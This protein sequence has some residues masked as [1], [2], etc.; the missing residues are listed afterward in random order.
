VYLQTTVGLYCNTCPQF[1]HR[2][3]NRPFGGRDLIINLYD[4][5]DN[6][7]TFDDNIVEGD[8]YVVPGLNA[9]FDVQEVFSVFTNNDPNNL[10]K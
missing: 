3:W 6:K 1:Q 9:S 5:D 2:C 10:E 8:N 4:D 7:K